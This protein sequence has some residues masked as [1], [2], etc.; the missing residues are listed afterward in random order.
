M[1]GRLPEPL[2]ARAGD[3]GSAIGIAGT[4]EVAGARAALQAGDTIGGL[5]NS[6]VEERVGRE[7]AK[8][9]SEL[10]S[11]LNGLREEAL[12]TQDPTALDELISTRFPQVEQEVLESSPFRS[13]EYDLAVTSAVDRARASLSGHRMAV[14]RED[15][16]ATVD[17]LSRSFAEDMAQIPATDP[18]I[19][20]ESLDA[21]RAN[22]DGL[23]ALSPGERERA[24]TSI[25]RSGALTFVQQQLDADPAAVAKLFDGSREEMIASDPLLQHLTPADRAKL[26]DV[27]ATALDASLEHE[28]AL[29]ASDLEIAVREGRLG[30]K[31]IDQA[32][33]AK[34]ITGK[35]RTELVLASR[36]LAE[37][38]ATGIA[39]RERF[40]A[41][42]DGD[43]LYDPTNKKDRK[44]VDALFNSSILPELEKLPAEARP[45][46]LAEVIGK[47]GIVPSVVRSRLQAQLYSGSPQDIVQAADTLD[48]LGAKNPALL[49][50][51]D[52]MAREV[53]TQVSTLVRAGVP[54]QEAVRR[55]ETARSQATSERD[56]RSQMYQEEGKANQRWLGSQTSS[57]FRFNEPEIPDAMRGEFELLVRESF[58]RTGE[59]ETARRTAL[60]DVKTVWAETGVNGRQEWMKYAPE[61]YYPAQGDAGWMREQLVVDVNEA[62]S[63]DV[64]Q[65]PAERIHVVPDLLTAREAALGR[66]TYT[67]LI[68][69]EK[70]GEFLPALNG[71]HPDYE[72]SPAG[73][74]ARAESEEK[75]SRARARRAA[76][77]A[78]DDR[79]LLDDFAQ[80]LA[81]MPRDTSGGDMLQ[82]HFFDPFLRGVRT[83]IATQGAVLGEIGKRGGIGPSRL[84]TQGEI[85]S[86]A[87]MRRRGESGEA[88]L[89][90]QRLRAEAR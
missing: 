86:A 61:A 44:Q 42:M 90:R 12:M 32:F 41:V 37:D 25:A 62:L 36:K 26:K 50:Q 47:V 80:A 76:I 54:P 8:G 57:V 19:Q 53:G 66:P 40:R 60:Q 49:R 22:L 35:K 5:I 30:E 72:T 9:L 16:Q 63:T 11:K 18:D 46:M 71:W 1:A 15:A 55:V 85:S 70:S 84:P 43:D 69:D 3:P 64:A 48:R 77:L 81:A 10:Q 45:A 74:A 20:G 56:V 31:A 28:R 29:A 68:Q 23:K 52:P 87:M 27:S 6:F 34:W 17:S 73:K 65:V 89:E 67:V 82:E 33:E 59:I 75:V 13:P 7:R 39:V 83:S 14:R 38:G 58:L 51:I 21:L 79:G 24:Y 2:P 78:G 4:A 88:F